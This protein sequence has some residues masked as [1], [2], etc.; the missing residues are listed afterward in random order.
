VQFTLW[1]DRLAG[2]LAD[3]HTE[4]ARCDG[5][6]FWTVDFI[7]TWVRALF[8]LTG[9]RLIS[10]APLPVSPLACLLRWARLAKHGLS[11]AQRF[12]LRAPDAM[13]RLAPLR[14]LHIAA[15]AGKS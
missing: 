9:R 4:C 7:G 12:A 8:V 11:A 1:Q 13:V 14:R 2:Y 6:T 3:S 15:A 5:L 10:A